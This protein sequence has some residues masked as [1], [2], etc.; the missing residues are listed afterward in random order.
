MRVGERTI[1]RRRNCRGADATP[2]RRR[3]R[4]VD[5]PPGRRFGGRPSRRRRGEPRCTS[6][7]SLPED[8]KRTAIDVES[9]DV[10]L[11]EAARSDLVIVGASTSGAAMRWLRTL[12]SSRRD[13]RHSCMSR[14]S[15]CAAT[16]LSRCVGSSSASTAPPHP[17][18]SSSGPLTRPPATT[19][20]WSSS[21]PGNQA[22]Q[23]GR[24]LR[25]NDLARA[26]ARCVVDLAVRRCETR[27][28]CTVRGELIE[29]EPADVLSAA[30]RDA[31]L[32]VVGSRGRSGF[33]TMLFGSGDR[34]RSS[35]SLTVRSP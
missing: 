10:L 30:S 24:S 34:A 23:P 26:D 28:T 4:R 7:R 8:S 31:D 33:T 17:Q 14:S 22:R 16:P 32:I 12:R 13:R 21:T 2:G 15:S 19:P 25:D 1:L 3:R 35:N 29:G 6:C 27:S 9:R 20:N 18:P 5:A 11:D